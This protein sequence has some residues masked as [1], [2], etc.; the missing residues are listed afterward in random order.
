[1]SC[2]SK[3]GRRKCSYPGTPAHG[4]GDHTHGENV[5]AR[6]QHLETRVVGRQR[7]FIAIAVP[8]PPSTKRWCTPDAQDLGEKLLRQRQ[9]GADHASA[10]AFAFRDAR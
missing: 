1:L 6:K 9:L 10:A 8:W 7:G 4:I 5:A 2:A 3:K